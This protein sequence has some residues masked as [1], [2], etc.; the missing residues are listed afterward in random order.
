MTTLFFG[1]IAGLT[2]AFFSSVSYLISRHHGARERHASRRL[3]IFAHVIMGFTC[4]LFALSS[5]SSEILFSQIW[6]WNIWLPCFVSTG[7]YFFGTSAV[8]RV[9]RRTEAS[10]LSPL[11]GL[12]I[13][14][15]GLI[16]SLVFGQTL[17][18]EQWFAVMLCAAAAI[19][20]QQGGSGLPVQSL[21]VL[22]CGCICFAIADLGIVEMIDAMQ[23]AV[24]LSRFS[25]GCLALLVTYVFI[26]LI[27]SPLALFEYARHPQPTKRDWLAA[28]EYSA[29]WLLAMFGLYA[30][31]GFVG[32]ILST[33]LQSTRG[34]VSVVLGAIVSG[35][36]WHQLESRVERNV[37][38]RRLFSALCMTAAIALSV[39]GSYTTKG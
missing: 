39:V 28:G 1:I 37:F 24:A 19:L 30:C 26:G 35:Q 23:D 17:S 7:T 33:I 2:A 3:L 9:L 13:I 25:V 29:A 38:C 6:R 20:L 5:Y 10:R 4:G 32:V 18:V 22:S 16:V 14:A 11:L 8:F 36:G 31:I 12:K 21:I 27:A 34:I 15:L